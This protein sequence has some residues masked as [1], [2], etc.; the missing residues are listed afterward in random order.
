MVNK[1]SVHDIL[2]KLKEIKETYCETTKTFDDLIIWV[3]H[4]VEQTINTKDDRAK[5]KLYYDDCSIEYFTEHL[6]FS[7]IKNELTGDGGHT[8]VSYDVA[9]SL[10]PYLKSFF[11]VDRLGVLREAMRLLEEDLSEVSAEIAK[12]IEAWCQNVTEVFNVT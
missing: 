1:T 10:E 3:N 4:C 11:G 9:I 5:Y 2:Y 8:G 7:I 12:D 6:L